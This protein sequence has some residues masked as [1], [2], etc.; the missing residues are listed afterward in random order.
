MTAFR[1]TWTR[2]D[3]ALP[4]P[5]TRGR[6]TARAPRWETTE[7]NPPVAAA[8]V[9]VELASEIGSLPP[10]TGQERES[11]R[12]TRT[13]RC[14]RRLC[15]KRGCPPAA[16][17]HSASLALGTI[18]MG[19]RYTPGRYL[20]PGPNR[21]DP[22]RQ[23]PTQSLSTA[24]FGSSS[25]PSV[26][27]AATQASPVRQVQTVRA[28][29]DPKCWAWWPVTARVRQTS[30]R[31]LESCHAMPPKDCAPPSAT[32]AWMCMSLRLINHGS[33]SSWPASIRPA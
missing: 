28:A 25:D 19:H 17:D 11:A 21:P 30:W 8:A 13:S 27:G 26:R 20:R 6:R 16:A 23:T 7:G 32:S 31:I 10:S 14:D 33:T 22:D 15:P 9:A 12:R 18:E 4:S 1:A 5:L 29:T 3:E 2:A 24:K